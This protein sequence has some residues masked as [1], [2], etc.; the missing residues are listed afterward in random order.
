MVKS[1]KSYIEKQNELTKELENANEELK[2]SR[3]PQGRQ[4]TSYNWALKIHLSTILLVSDYT[5]Q[6]PCVRLIAFY[7]WTWLTRTLY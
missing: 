2:L 7:T 5:I 4:V 3:T 1:L 6:V